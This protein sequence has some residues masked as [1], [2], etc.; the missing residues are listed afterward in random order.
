MPVD[1]RATLFCR[2]CAA[3]L[4]LRLSYRSLKDADSEREPLRRLLQRA[5]ALGWVLQERGDYC[6]RCV[7]P[8]SEKEGKA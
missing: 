6:P 7:A 4:D 3:S 5:H 2:S 8:Q 1:L